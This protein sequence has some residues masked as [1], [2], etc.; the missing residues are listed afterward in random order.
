M[1]VY[2]FIPVFK[3]AFA[4]TNNYYV[5]LIGGWKVERL[6]GWNWIRKLE[7]SC[8]TVFWSHWCA[9]SAEMAE[10]SQSRAGERTLDKRGQKS[11]TDYFVKLLNKMYQ[12][13]ITNWRGVWNKTLSAFWCN[14]KFSLSFIT[15]YKEIWKEN[16]VIYL[17]SLK[18]FLQAT[19]Q[20][21]L[22]FVLYAVLFMFEVNFKC[23][24]VG[25]VGCMLMCKYTDFCRRMTKLLNLWEGMVQSAGP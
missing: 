5:L 1:K 2:D 6:G 8:K 11:C 23:I 19:L 24:W 17:K 13:F 9:M 22:S 12:K 16:V 7:G 14:V 4:I 25:L 3:P 20:L 21:L 10:G 18:A 15:E